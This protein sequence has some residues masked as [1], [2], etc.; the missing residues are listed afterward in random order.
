M[1]R[2]IHYFRMLEEKHKRLAEVTGRYCIFQ[3][4]FAH[5]HYWWIE[6]LER[7]VKSARESEQSEEEGEEEEEKEEENAEDR[8]DGLRER[9]PRRRSSSCSNWTILFV[10]GIQSRLWVLI[11][12][13]KKEVF[14]GSFGDT[15]GCPNS[16]SF[17]SP[18]SVVLL[19]MNWICSVLLLYALFPS[20]EW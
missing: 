10:E 15:F 16:K 9:H 4:S 12:V 19:R 3:S 20:F 5:F 18:F 11:C 14:F 2:Q 6:K 7:V 1:N 17:S 8:N 13:F